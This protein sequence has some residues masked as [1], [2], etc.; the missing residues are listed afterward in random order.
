MSCNRGVWCKQAPGGPERGSGCV[1]AVPIDTSGCC[2]GQ[3]CL[4]DFEGKKNQ[5]VFEH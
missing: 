5:A 1:A 3:N 2:E 4:I